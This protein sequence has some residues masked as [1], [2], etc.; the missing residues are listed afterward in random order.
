MAKL[1]INILLIL[2]LVITLCSCLPSKKKGIT[3]EGKTSTPAAYTIWKIEEA[4]KEAQ[5]K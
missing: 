2:S 3:L 1:F 5:G 4:V